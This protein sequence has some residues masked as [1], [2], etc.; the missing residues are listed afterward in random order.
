MRSIWTLIWVL[1]IAL[2]RAQT[3]EPATIAAQRLT[4]A[5][6][7]DGV[8][9]EAEWAE[10]LRIDSFYDPGQGR[11]AEF[12]T[13]AF[14]GYTADAIYVAFVCDDPEP[15]AIRAQ[16]VRRDGDMENDDCVVFAVDPQGQRLT[17]YQFIVNP[18]GTQRL[19]VPVGAS[20][21]VRWRGD[22]QAAAQRTERGWSA[23]MR[24]PF[25][26][27]RYP[28]GQRWFGVALVRLITRLRA[29][30]VFPQAGSLYDLRLQTRWGALE[31][32]RQ[33][34]PIVALPY[35]LSESDAQ[36]SRSQVGIDLKWRSEQGQ[37]ALLTVNPDFSTIAADVAS[38]DF[39]YTE[40]FLRETRPFFTEGENLFPSARLF[41]S[42][43]VPQLQAGLKLFGQT[44]TLEYGLLGGEFEQSRQRS[45]F[46][47]GQTRYRFNPS[48][49]LGVAFTTLEG[50]SRE[51]LVAVEGA[52]GQLTGAGEWQLYGLRASLSG[53]REGDYT[54][55]RL[56]RRAPPRQLAVWMTYTDLAPNFAPRLA[57]VP[58]RG[59]R[60][61]E[62]DLYYVEQPQ[63]FVLAQGARISAKRRLLYGGGT[64]DE[65]FSVGAEV[66][67]RTQ[68]A[69][70]AQFDWLR[71][72]PN[73]DRY[74][75]LL[76]QWNFLDAARNGF[77][78]L[79]AGDQNGGR[80]RYVSVQQRLEP[81]PRLRLGITLEALRIDYANRPRDQSVQA[82]VTLNYEL[83]PE[84]VLGGRWVNNRIE[85][86][87]AAVST[88]NF[89]LTYA[90]Q[91][92][93]GQEVYLLLGL[94]NAKRTQNRVALKLV[95]PIEW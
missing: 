65:G 28:A 25:R 79:L 59:W 39:S 63:R 35:L 32:P 91:L 57:F 71:R 64:L 76:I 5:P 24:I 36:A 84:R 4:Q 54:L 14:L 69:Y 80:S 68:V 30:Y 29:V 20:L 10:A 87:G 2:V 6:V 7:I 23:E 55:V 78:Y 44:G 17:P 73:T 66:Y 48:S 67:L 42:V 95:S 75:A 19:E 18:L 70:G 83:T 74:G 94:P 12:P 27:L 62:I 90:Q 43:R 53:A 15:S 31:L 45:R 33:R 9:D 21:N 11:A 3:V 1:L 72:P 86:G 92:R 51:Q 40:R 41:Y 85:S 88:N 47:V 49:F 82:V 26:L 60:G 50:V 61:Y 46:A 37:V 16:Q 52:I 77:L 93:T 22:W 34:P 56:G 38:V 89:Y 81:L 8:V 13:R 58:E